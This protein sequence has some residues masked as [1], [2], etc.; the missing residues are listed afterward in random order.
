MIDTD[1][2]VGERTKS[3]HFGARKVVRHVDAEVVDLEGRM[4]HR[5]AVGGVDCRCDEG[6]TDL[7]LVVG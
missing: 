2:L 5:I 6:S 4:Y 1:L 3:H 7:L